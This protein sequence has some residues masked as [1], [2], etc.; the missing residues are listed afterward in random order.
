MK[1]KWLW[2]FLLIL[3]IVLTLFTCTK[4]RIR[5]NQDVTLVFIYGE[6]NIN[7]VLPEDEAAKVI[8]ILNGNSYDLSF[9]AGYPSCGFSQ[10]VALK[11]GN[12]NFA[13]ACD[14]CNCVRDGLTLMCFDIPKEDMAYIHSLF[15]KYGGYFPCI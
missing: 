10:N 7:V 12:R 1:R 13:I 14:T 4:T 2:T 15:E 9:W 11:V 5:A 8:E 3:V 6:K